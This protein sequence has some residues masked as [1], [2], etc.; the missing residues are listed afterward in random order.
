MM[1]L[2]SYGPTLRS[3]EPSHVVEE[4]TDAKL[5]STVHC[6]PFESLGSMQSRPDPF[7]SLKYKL[8]L[9]ILYD[10]EAVAD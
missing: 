8:T 10:V 1:S 2:Y 6:R 7:M 9:K 3:H 4:V 5:I